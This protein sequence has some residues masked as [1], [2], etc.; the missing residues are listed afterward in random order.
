MNTQDNTETSSASAQAKAPIHVSPE[1]FTTLPSPPNA[2]FVRKQAFDDGHVWVGIVT[3]EPG[4]ASPWHHHG[5]YD[6]YVYVLEG[7]GTVEFGE[8]G[9]ESMT[10]SADG[11]LAKVP[12]GLV[13]RKMN[14]AKVPNKFLIVRVGEGEPVI[15]AEPLGIGRQ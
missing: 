15:P 8:G 3:T 12:K 13:H 10:I 7:E 6:T 2:P 9:K 1:T 5:D 4:A 14:N 11:S